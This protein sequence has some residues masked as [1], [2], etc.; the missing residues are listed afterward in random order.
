MDEQKEKWQQEL[1]NIEQK[2]N[3]LLQGQKRT[4]RQKDAGKCDG[5]L[6]RTRD[7]IAEREVQY[8]ELSHKSQRRSWTK[9]LETCRQERKDAAVVHLTLTDAVL[10]HQWWNIFL[11]MGTAQAMQHLAFPE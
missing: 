3:D 11:T 9:K 6:E 5:D 2:R 8:Q 10:T 7:E 4:Q 1:Q